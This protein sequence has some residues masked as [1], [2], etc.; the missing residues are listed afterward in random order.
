M[1]IKPVILVFLV[2]VGGTAAGLFDFP[3][4]TN[5]AID[6][7]NEKKNEVGLQGMPNVPRIPVVPFQLGLDLQGGIHLVY[8]ADL[9]GVLSLEHDSAM[10]GLR[11][12]IERRVNLFGVNEPLVQTEGS[13]DNRRLIVELAGISDPNLAI[14]LI[15]QTPFLEFAEPKENY[16]EISQ[17]NE[18][19]FA[20]LIEGEVE[21]ENPFKDNSTLTG[22]YLDKAEIGFGHLVQDPVINLQFNDEGAEIF[23]GMTE[24][25]IGRP[26]GIFLDGMLLQA[27]IVQ[28][29]IDGGAAQISGGFTAESARK[30]VRELNAG[31]L[32]VPISLLSQQSVGPQLGQISLE[33]SLQAGIIGLLAVALF[34]IVFYRIPGVFASLSLLIYVAVMLAIFKLIPVTLTLAGFAGVILSIGMA[35]DANIL[36]FSRTR[37]ELKD[38]KSLGAAIEEGFKRAWPSIRDGNITTLL[39]ALILF[40][41]GSSFVQGFALTLSIGILLSMFSAIIV[42]KSFL[43]FFGN[44]ILGRLTF[45]WK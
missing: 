26:I 45:L 22:R 36:I 6:S 3:D 35:V 32:P 18:D 16:V 9:E 28:T 14:Q 43:L 19:I 21:L 1:K 38:G 24:R 23:R 20:G 30:I 40:W 4:R 33:K 11:D 41:F 29:E 42:T 31:A 8:Q 25:N 13:G 12:V 34:M 39:V 37:E 17:R 15:G 5:P 44:G 10:E 27:P 2:L 7:L